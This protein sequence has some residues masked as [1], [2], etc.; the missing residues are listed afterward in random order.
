[1]RT[2]P[3]RARNFHGELMRF[4]NGPINKIFS[5][6]GNPLMRFNLGKRND[7]EVF[8]WIVWQLSDTGERNCSSDRVRS[9]EPAVKVD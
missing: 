6:Q 1:M 9:K 7:G 4:T 2:I 8:G 5:S 3:I